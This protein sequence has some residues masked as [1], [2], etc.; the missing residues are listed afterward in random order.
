MPEVTPE[1]LQRLKRRHKRELRQA[2][3]LGVLQGVTSFL[4]PGDV[5]VD[6]GANCGDVTAVL[7]ETGATVHAFEPDPFNLEKLH[8]RFSGTSNVHLHAVAVGVRAG[9]V[10]LMRAANWDQNPH[11]A[12]VK[13]TVVPGGTNI[14]DANGIDVDC[15]DL[16]AFLTAMADRHGEVAFVKLDIEGAELD[17]LEAMHGNQL[18]HR[19]RLTVA[20]THEHKFRALRPRFAALRKTLT[21]TW[22]A[23]RVNLDWC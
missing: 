22:P 11:L 13:S 19:I 2:R 7:A 16:P 3:A 5:A 9:L 14:D 4:R 15:I 23:N 20:E 21:A 8:D 10:Q 17:I 6:C 12:S 1:D 18:F